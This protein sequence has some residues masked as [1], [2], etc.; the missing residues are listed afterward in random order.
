MT[1]ECRCGCCGSTLQQECQYTSAGRT[2]TERDCSGETATSVDELATIWSGNTCLSEFT[3]ILEPNSQYDSTQLPRVQADFDNLL[4]T[5]LS[6]GYN[7]TSNSN[8]PEYNNFQNTLISTCRNS[9]LPGA[10]DL[11][12]EDYCGIHTRGDLELNSPLAN[13]CGCYIQSPTEN[14]NGSNCDPFCNQGSA[15]Q[16]ADSCS[17]LFSTCP[18][19]VCTIT[20]GHPTLC[21]SCQPGSGC[22]CTF[23]SIDSTELIMRTGMN[24]V[25]P[26][27]CNVSSCFTPSQGGLTQAQCPQPAELTPSKPKSILLYLIIAVVVVLIIIAVIIAAI[28]R[29]TQNINDRK[30][31]SVVSVRNPAI[32]T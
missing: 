1:T 21:Q 31:G 9:S 22:N 23:V 8:S 7:F 26:D 4:N 3:G 28:A 18:S 2:Q 25:Y 17:G 11:F 12:L 27:Y 6:F 14:I 29:R 5:Y 10:C 16:R 13:L 15:V 30:Y 20:D 19:N 24:S 32:R